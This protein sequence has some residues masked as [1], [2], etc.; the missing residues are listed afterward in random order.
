[1]PWEWGDFFSGNSTKILSPLRIPEQGPERAYRML[2]DCNA[3]QG[4]GPLTGP[5]LR[6]NPFQGV[7]T[8]SLE[9]PQ[10][11]P[12]LAVLPYWTAPDTNP[13]HS[14]FRNLNNYC[15]PIGYSG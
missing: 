15:H 10:S 3:F 14:E 2:P 13:C 12:G 1:M 9:L 8:F 7:L 4:T 11:S 6:V 5:S